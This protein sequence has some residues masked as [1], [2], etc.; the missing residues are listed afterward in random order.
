MP[1]FFLRW[2]PHSTSRGR[3]SCPHP[4][5]FKD[6]EEVVRK[7]WERS[8]FPKWV[9]VVPDAMVGFSCRSSHLF[10][11]LPL[12]GW[13]HHSDFKDEDTEPQRRKMTSSTF[14][15]WGARILIWVWM[16]PKLLPFPLHPV[17]PE[18]DPSTSTLR[19][20]IWDPFPNRRYPQ[21]FILTWMLLFKSLEV[22]NQP[23]DQLIN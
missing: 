17:F 2:T 10:L 21:K 19:Q 16:T 20:L 12:W 3:Y 5:S 4:I 18:V 14:P 1:P 13:W 11:I 6:I 8:C 7:D 23:T 22:W 9:S 15:G